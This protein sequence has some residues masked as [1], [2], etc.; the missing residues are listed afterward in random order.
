MSLLKVQRHHLRLSYLHQHYG[1]YFTFLSSWRIFFNSYHF[2]KGKFCFA[3]FFFSFLLG[4]PWSAQ[5]R[6][7]GVAV[8][9]SPSFNARRGIKI[10]Y[11]VQTTE[12][13]I[14]FLCPMLITCCMFFPRKQTWQGSGRVRKA[15][16]RKGHV[17]IA[18]FSFLRPGSSPPRLTCRGQPP[19]LTCRGQ[20][21]SQLW[22]KATCWGRGWFLLGAPHSASSPTVVTIRPRNHHWREQI[23]HVS[24]LSRSLGAH[25]SENTCIPA[26]PPSDIWQSPKTAI[27]HTK[28]NTTQNPTVTRPSNDCSI[29]QLAGSSA[30]CSELVRASSEADRLSV[31]TQKVHPGPLF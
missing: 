5:L 21:L 6:L 19:R 30:G 13:S 14:T 15:S 7:R 27:S 18:P 9:S 1:I 12:E 23:Y 31:Q 24:P 2:C 29:S 22:G 8:V 10:K 25:R 26:C 11:H 28:H 17:G 16:I 4:N 3:S 20:Q